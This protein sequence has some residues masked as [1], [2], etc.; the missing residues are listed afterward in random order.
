MHSR[1]WSPRFFA[2]VGL[3][4]VAAGCNPSAATNGSGGK[5]VRAT[6]QSMCGSCHGP[7]GRPPAAMVERLAVRDLTSAEFRGRATP[8]LIEHQIRK[9]S[10]NKLMPSFEGV[11]DDAQI[12][13]LAELVAS[14]QFV[15]P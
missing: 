12:K 11:L 7:D 1:G 15:Q 6:F 14:P 13:A 5:D 8:A 3:A 4:L 9:G 2:A 10:T